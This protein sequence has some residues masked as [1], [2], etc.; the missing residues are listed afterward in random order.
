MSATFKPGE[1][2]PRSGIY[3]V[4]H[5]EHRLDHSVTLLEGE[6]FPVCRQCGDHV[7]FRLQD[8]SAETSA[9]HGRF[10]VILEEYSSWR[11]DCD[12]TSMAA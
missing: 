2:A 7:L 6:Q 3:K 12:S 1:T 11:D 4:R 10:R 9:V 5:V 8:A